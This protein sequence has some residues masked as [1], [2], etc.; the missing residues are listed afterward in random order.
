MD[1]SNL[2]VITSIILLTNGQASDCP[3]SL[4]CTIHSSS[5]LGV[6]NILRIWSAKVTELGLHSKL[7]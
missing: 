7:F 4:A 1:L 5:D 3:C 2:L 6:D